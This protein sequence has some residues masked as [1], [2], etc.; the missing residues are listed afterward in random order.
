V[1]QA[2]YRALARSRHPDI[3]RDPDAEDQMRRLNVA[4]QTLSDPVRRARYDEELVLESAARS[5]APRPA[6]AASSVG[7]SEDADVAAAPPPASSAP[8]ASAPGARAR[9]T[10]P[11][12]RPAAPAH[13]YQAMLFDQRSEGILSRSALYLVVVLVT[14]ILAL[15]AYI[16]IDVIASEGP[17]TA[18]RGPRT[19]GER[20]WTPSS[21]PRSWLLESADADGR[22]GL[23]SSGERWNR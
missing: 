18:P 16:I 23:S 11:G 17:I 3:N 4:Y 5:A 9:A 8:H 7:A 2:A 14:A 20:T 1:I 13:T 22:P 21:S 12:A 6:T 15:F 19:Q 10:R